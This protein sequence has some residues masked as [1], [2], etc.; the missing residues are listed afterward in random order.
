MTVE[1]FRH[2]VK[3]ACIA[4]GSQRAFALKNGI[5]PAYVGEVLDGTRLPGPLMLEVM[6][7]R[8][9]VTYERIAAD[10]DG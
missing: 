5:S 4:A 3:L 10:V 8:R 9:R 7:M 1:E 2:E 6:G